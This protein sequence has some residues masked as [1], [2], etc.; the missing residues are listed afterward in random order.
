MACRGTALP[1][2]TLLKICTERC[3]YFLNLDLTGPEIYMKLLPIEV[4]TVPQDPLILLC[5]KKNTFVI[6]IC[7]FQ[8]YLN[9]MN[10]YYRIRRNINYWIKKR[11]HSLSDS[12]FVSA[13]SVQNG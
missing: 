8:L 9:L 4:S 1:V 3:E 10:G 6:S 7:N 13:F 5:D 11:R 2:F 12:L